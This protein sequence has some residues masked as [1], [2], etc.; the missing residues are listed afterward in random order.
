[1]AEAFKVLLEQGGMT[2]ALIIVVITISI[3][4][5]KRLEKKDTQFEEFLKGLTQTI[6]I[7]NEAFVAHNERASLNHQSLMNSFVQVQ[8]DHEKMLDYHTKVM[9]ALNVQDKAI[10]DF[11]K[12]VAE[13]KCV[14]RN[15]EKG[16]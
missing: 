2:G 14:L 11:D 6:K 5:I 10:D 7:Q 8:K 1:M 3:M 9:M 15:L 16:Q 4:L 13:I 12:D